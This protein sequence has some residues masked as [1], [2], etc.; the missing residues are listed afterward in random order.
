MNFIE[1]ISYSHRS[2][3]PMLSSGTD[4]ETVLKTV[5]IALE[6]YHRAKAPV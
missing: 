5:S 2:F 1:S 4:K 6:L 3:S